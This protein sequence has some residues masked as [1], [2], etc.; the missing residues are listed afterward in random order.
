MHADEIVVRLV[1]GL[2]LLGL[3]AFVV[4]EYVKA[5]RVIWQRYR[6]SQNANSEQSS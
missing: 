2:G 6:T 4:R 1:L 5:E 3:A